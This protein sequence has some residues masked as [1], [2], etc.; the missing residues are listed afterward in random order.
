MSGSMTKEGQDTL[1]TWFERYIDR[2]YD[3]DGVLH[4]MLE[5]KR[6]H[7]LRVAE[8]A[9][10]IAAALSFPEREQR[11]AEGVGLVHDVGRFTQFAQHGSFRDADTVDHGAEG[12]R[13]LEAQDLFFLPDSGE[14]ER[15]FCVVEYHNRKGTDIPRGLRPEQ[16]RLLRLIRDADKLDIMELV[17]RAVAADGFQDLPGMLPHIRLCRELSP[18]V[19][20]EAAKTES[21]S[22]GNLSTLADFLIMMATWCY[23]LNYPPT[24]RLAVQRDIL[25]RIRRELPDMKAIRELFASITEA[26]LK[27]R[28]VKHG[29]F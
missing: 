15:L 26:M 27:R 12:R 24:R 11:L 29:T 3:R 18:E 4:P 16:D 22:S 9:R 23:D 14:R 25:P 7:S 19:L 21:V 2:F 1:Q 8:N 17:L 5:L 10:F 20:T 6:R 28:G 13:V